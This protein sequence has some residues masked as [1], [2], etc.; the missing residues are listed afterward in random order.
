MNIIPFYG[1]THPDLFAIERAAMDRQGRVVS[2]LDELLPEDGTVLDIGA[3]DG[4][5][6]EALTTSRRAVFAMEPARAMVDSRRS[7]CWVCGEAEALPYRAAR[8]RAAYATWAFFFPS[9]HAI[10][11]GIA[12]MERVVGPGGSLAIVN[13]LGDDGFCRLS[14]RNIAEPPEPF[15]ERGFALDVVETAFEF[16]T[17]DDARRLLGFYFGDQGRARARLRMS[18]RV[19][20]YHKRVAGK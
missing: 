8:F 2:A 11:T 4:F 7:L 6:A 20:V 14:P 9:M 5:T 15:I 17:V 12:E 10:D 3:G 19:G 1:T 13:N 16:D 18:F